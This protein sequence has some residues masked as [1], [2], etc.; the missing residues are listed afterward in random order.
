MKFK[1]IDLISSLIHFIGFLLSVCALVILIIDAVKHGTIWHLVSFI[2]FGASLMLMYSTSMVYHAIPF[3]NRKKKTFQKLD[4]QMIFVL[5]FGT[6]TPICLVC[7]REE[8]GWVLLGLILILSILGIIWKSIRIKMKGV[9]GAL[10]TVVYFIM[11]LLIFI[12][13]VPL[14]ECLG[15]RG[16]L[17][18]IAGGIFYIIGIVFF[19][20]D[21]YMEKRTVTMHDVFHVILILAT[22]CH[23]WVMFRY[24]L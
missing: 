24:V 20:L 14:F 1:N 4:H 3:H 22:Y 18:F 15:L 16:F 17:W 23:F 19:V 9:L 6:Y 12:L 8:G 2:I 5:I 7:L 13:V 21:Y 10:S 11:G